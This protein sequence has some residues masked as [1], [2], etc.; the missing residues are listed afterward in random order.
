MRTQRNATLTFTATE[1]LVIS[2]A[3]YANQIRAVCVIT[4]LVA[5][6]GNT[7][8]ISVGEEGAANKGIPL[9]PGQSFVWSMDSGYIPPSDRISGYSAGA[10]SIAI[11]EEI[12]IKD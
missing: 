3:K 6:G 9:A 5:A 8:Y 1:P 11:Y 7:I 4:S 2:E 12:I 10:D